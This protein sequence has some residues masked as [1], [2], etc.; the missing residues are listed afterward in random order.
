MRGRDPL[1]MFAH[2]NGLRRLE[3]AARAV[4]QF[5]KIHGSPF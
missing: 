2:R 5:L 3:E 4:G 1:M